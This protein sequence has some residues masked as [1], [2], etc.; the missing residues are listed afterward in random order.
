[1]RH[2]NRLH[3][4]EKASRWQSQDSNPVRA[5]GSRILAPNQATGISLLLSSVPSLRETNNIISDSG[6]WEW[7][8]G[9]EYADVHFHLFF[10][11][12]E[13]RSPWRYI[14]TAVKSYLKYV[15]Q[16]AL[17]RSYLVI[18]YY[19]EPLLLL[20]SIFRHSCVGKKK[21][22][23]YVLEWSSVKSQNVL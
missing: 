4:F 18:H 22:F 5:S 16:A 6:S 17:P 23:W 15:S 19:Q 1:M 13:D 10:R 20:K 14:V 7:D 12:L 21:K 9:K 3:N 8:V 11:E 2:K